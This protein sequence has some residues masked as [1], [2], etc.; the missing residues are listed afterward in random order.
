MT[1]GNPMNGVAKSLD[2]NRLLEATGLA[3]SYGGHL[4][5]RHVEFDISSHEIVAVIGENGAGKSTLAKIIAGAVQPESG[6]LRLN[7]RVIQLQ[8]PRDALRLGI[9]YIPQ[10]LAYL[11]NMSVGDNILVGRWPHRAGVTGDLAV[12]A[13]AAAE[14]RRFGIEVD[15]SR[16]MADLTL[17]ER[18]LVEIAKALSR[19]SAVLVLDEPTAS[20][21]NAESGNL[22]RV[23]KQLARAG[24]AVVFI[25]HRMDEV[26]EVSDRVVVMRNGAIVGNVATSATKRSELIGLMLGAA[27]QELTEVHTA[28]LVRDTVVD[29]VDWSSSGQPPIRNFS[30]AVDRGEIVCLFGLRGSGGEAIAEGL[31]GRNRKVEGRVAIEGKSYQV[32][33]GPA[34]ARRAGIGYVPAE[35]KRDGLVMPLSVQANLSLLVLSLVSRFG[36]LRPSAERRLGERLRSRMRIRYRS[37]SQSVATLSGGNQ[38]KVLLASRLAANP[39]VFVLQEPT[40]GVDVGAR[41]EIHQYV[42]SIAS[43]GTPVVWITTDVE[44]A[45]LIADRLVVMREGAVVAELTGDSKTQGRALEAATNDAA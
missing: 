13:L 28:K 29:I 43:Q 11:P 38:Q 16:R 33:R 2:E 21:T 35:R 7:G 20:L 23:L 32:F 40:R 10:E 30:L 26:F 18:Q 27:A 15:V 41:Y 3:K 6:E 12:R 34:A 25:S 45:V 17:A 4:V 39:K 19:S 22:F 9:A 42:R 1:E 44:E 37:S 14:V 36:W 31:A 8:S 5:L 24:L